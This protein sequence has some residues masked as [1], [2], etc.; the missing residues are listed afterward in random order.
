MKR[1]TP[2]VA[3]A[4]VLCGLAGCNSGW[5]GVIKDR[6]RCWNEAADVFATI[7]DEQTALQ[8]RPKLM[9]ILDR[10]AELD[11]RG[12]A[13]APASDDKVYEVRM[14]NQEAVKTANDRINAQMDRAA[15]VPGGAEVVYEFNY[16]LRQGLN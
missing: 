8:A 11:R 6:V 16:K 14:N 9:A 2:F 15:A 12:K 7:R 5:D 4:L 3:A 1:I 10:M 13:I